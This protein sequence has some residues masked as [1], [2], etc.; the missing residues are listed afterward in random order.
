L[1][2]FPCGCNHSV[3]RLARGAFAVHKMYTATNKNTLNLINLLAPLH[4]AFTLFI[5]TS[6]ASIRWYLSLTHL[7]KNRDIQE[8]SHSLTRPEVIIT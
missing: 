7:I 1:E 2:R 3:R 6:G 4:V 5:V 8:V